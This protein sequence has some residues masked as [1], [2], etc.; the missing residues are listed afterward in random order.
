MS[1]RESSVRVLTV[2]LDDE[3]YKELL[4]AMKELGIRNH[5]DTLRFLIRQHARTSK[6]QFNLGV[7]R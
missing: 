1:I 2:R 7:G 5:S 4:L 6:L 3:S